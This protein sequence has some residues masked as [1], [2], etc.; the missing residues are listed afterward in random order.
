MAWSGSDLH[1]RQNCRVARLCV[2][3]GSYKYE[4]RAQDGITSIRTVVP[5]PR[6]PTS[7]FITC[8]LDEEINFDV[9]DTNVS[10]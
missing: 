5:E 1:I 6:N 2:L 8:G 7:H 4:V 3:E 9:Y 10:I